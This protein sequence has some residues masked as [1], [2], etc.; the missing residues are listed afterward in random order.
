MVDTRDPCCSSGEA[1]NSWDSAEDSTFHE[2]SEERLRE[3]SGSLEGIWGRI[4]EPDLVNQEAKGLWGWCQLKLLNKQQQEV[5]SEQVELTEDL[6]SA[7]ISTWM[8]NDS[9]NQM[10]DLK[11]I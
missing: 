7:K 4:I 3:H 8:P 11:L 2:R 5:T 9:R 1:L 6:S 10:H